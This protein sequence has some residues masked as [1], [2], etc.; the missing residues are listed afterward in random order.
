MSRQLLITGATGF[1]GG[2]V[3][4]RLKS[5][6]EWDIVATGRN[7][8]RGKQLK[9]VEFMPADLRHSGSVAELVRNRFSVIHCAALTAP[10]GK[11]S[12]FDTVNFHVTQS[13]LDASI[14]AG[15][16][17]F[18]YI[19]T[20]SIYAEFADRT[21]I[22]EADPPVDPPINHYTRTKLAAERYVLSRA[23]DIQV[24]V[25]RPHALIGVGDETILPRLL[26]AARKHLLPIIGP[27]DN[28][29]DLTCVENAAQACWLALTAGSEC[30]GQAYNITNNEPVLLWDCL[31]DFLHN[32]GIP[33]PRRRIS[34]KAA[35]RLAS[36][37]EFFADH[38]QRKEPVL[39][40][41][42]V[43]MLGYTHTFNISKARRE[44]RYEP[45]VRLEEGLDRTAAW[46]RAKNRV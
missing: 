23:S 34:I 16:T 24:I 18:I 46:H 29:A 2:A 4:E 38:I 20:P 30:V 39:T 45:L 28:R 35:L 41:Y 37:F 12:D 8:E 42:G 32:A 27:G 25:L 10:W 14:T 40:K 26:R 43:A 13:L 3:C 33:V 17:R 1:L 19:S 9:E 44:L 6:N 31:R 11:P 22:V 15:V 5:E 7:L 36:V 21:D